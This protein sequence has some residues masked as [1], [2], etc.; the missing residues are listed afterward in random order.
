[1]VADDIKIL[2]DSIGGTRKPIILNTLPRQQQLYEYV[3]YGVKIDSKI[4]VLMRVNYI[5][6]VLILE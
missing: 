4:T 2:E 1:M 6:E 3:N 5:A